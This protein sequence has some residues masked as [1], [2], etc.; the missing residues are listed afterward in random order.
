MKL[1]PGWRFRKRIERW[2]LPFLICVVLC[3]SAAPSSARA[4]DWTHWRGP[5]QDGFSPENNLPDTFSPATPGKNNL[6]WKAP[7]G[8]RSTPLVHNGHVYINGH[9]GDGITSQEYVAALDVKTGK[10]AW[11]HKFNLFLTDIV[12]ARVCWTNLAADPATGTVYNHGTQGLLTAFDGKTGKILWQ[13]S[14]TEEFGRI[15]GYGGRLCSPIVDGDLVIQ[16]IICAAWGEYARGGTRVIAFDKRDG[17]VVWWGS[18]GYRVRNT[19]Q[20]TPTVATIN[21]ERLIIVGGGDGGLHAFKVGTGEKVWTYILND[22][23]VNCSPVVAGTLV[24]ACHGGTNVDSNRQ[25]RVVC[26]DA[27]KVKDG[28][29]AEVWRVDGLK[30]KLTSPLL[31][32]GRLY[33]NDD[34]ANLYCLN[35]ADGKE[36]WKLKFG[37]GSNNRCCPVWADGKIYVSDAG[38]YFYILKPGDKKCQR[39]HRQLLISRSAGVDAELDG[40][41]AVA[42]GHVFF[43]TNDTTY[44]IGTPGEKPNVG[45]GS[46]EEAAPK[47][48][49]PAHLQVV[50]AEV[51]LAPGES[52]SFKAR[53][54]NDKGHF[55]REVKAEWSLA[56]ML[57]PEPG[58]GLPPPPKINPPALKGKLTD[59]G[60]LTV[61][62]GLQ[63][64]FGGVVAKAE[65]LT[66]R[67]RVRQVPRLPYV[68]NFD[69]LPP[70]AVPG[71][72]VNAQGKFAIRK[73]ANGNVLVKLANQP[74]PLLAQAHAYIGP[75]TLTDYTIQADTRG[76]QVGGNLPLMG[77]TA[78]RYTLH[79]VG[80]TQQLRLVSY[81]A[82]PRVDK[83]ISYPW[84]AGVWYR[85]KLTVHLDG[86]KAVIR[87]KVW[88]AL[89]T[90]PENWTLEVE[91]P[92]PNRSGSPALY[93]RATGIPPG[94][95]GAEADFA[96]V[97]ITPNKK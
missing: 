3:C 49:K 59:D 84:K 51:S 81:E 1:L 95:L 85:M 65:G 54:Y 30:I 38:S 87:G 73:I 35:A 82:L 96:N 8:C 34:G 50:P 36:L 28:K 79:L 9:T 90:E 43:C 20:S 42:N 48:S 71:G 80:D 16:T 41:P 33:L 44:C 94:G 72:W 47:D 24:Y 63:G 25:G 14:L 17:H 62:A 64:Q 19:H 78:N 69:K 23:A 22:G 60:K 70:G 68:S 67:A 12:P 75:P 15:S 31:Y 56:P 66:G 77:V 76:K 6:V 45:V 97:K 13:H 29:P 40:S 7:H 21:G 46:G 83:T 61:P 37:R 89:G 32:K 88:Q 18:A 74:S 86:G 11:E 57:A 93:A 39:L 58:V 55:L 92:A 52:A 53:L 10:L 26:L 5:L 4:G 91:D 2:P 27:G